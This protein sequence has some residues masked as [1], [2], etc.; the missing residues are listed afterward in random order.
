MLAFAL[1]ACSNGG[2]SNGGN[3]NDSGGAGQNT[4]KDLPTLTVDQINSRFLKMSFC[5]NQVRATKQGP[6]LETYTASLH[7]EPWSLDV[8]VETL[9]EVQLLNGEIHKHQALIRNN[10]G[11]YTENQKNFLSALQVPQALSALDFSRLDFE[12]LIDGLKLLSQMQG[13]AESN[14]LNKELTPELFLGN[15]TVNAFES[16]ICKYAKMKAEDF[17]SLEKVAAA[18]N[19]L[20]R[21]KAGDDSAATI[22]INLSFAKFGSI[23]TEEIYQLGQNFVK[24]RALDYAE[25][26]A[27]EF[28][29]PEKSQQVFVSYTVD[30]K[31]YRTI[32]LEKMKLDCLLMNVFNIESVQEILK[33][34][35]LHRLYINSSSDRDTIQ[36]FKTGEKDSTSNPQTTYVHIPNQ[37]K[38]DL[39]TIDPQEIAKTLLDAA[40]E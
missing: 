27:K 11:S 6:N 34:G 8:L 15:Q 39:N 37:T 33:Q 19:W 40:H 17:V 18:G 12:N 31:Y 25:E 36:V 5:K 20:W 23:S 14:I 24:L 7:C 16:Q 2:D 28:T 10:Q 35:T 21:F 30:D 38:V 1:L 13:K 3:S 22:K 4:A 29:G 26:K 9:Q 32:V